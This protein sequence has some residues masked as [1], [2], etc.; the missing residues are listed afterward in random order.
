MLGRLS[1]I[2]HLHIDGIDTRSQ[3]KKAIKRGEVLI[4]GRV[5]RTGDQVQRG[6][7]LSYLPYTQH[8]PVLE[9][10][11]DVVYEDSYLCIVD[12]PA[13]LPVSGNRY[14]QLDNCLSYNLTA[15]PLEDS[16]AQPL[17]VHRLDKATS[18]LL[19]CSKTRAAHI[20]LSE[21]LHDRRI[22]KWYEAIV[23]GKLEGNGSLITPIDGKRALTTY[24]SLT[25]IPSPRYDYLTHLQLEI[26]TGRTHQIRRHCAL[27]GHPIMGDQ[28]YCPAQLRRSKGLRLQACRLAFTHPITGEPLN[29]CLPFKR[30]IEHNHRASASQDEQDLRL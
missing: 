25:I 23:F 21:Q 24:S 1:D 27:A 14:R 10:D 6:D 13:G 29:L 17:P 15:S 26:E 28:L 19:I 30:G 22:R 16:L 2:G 8:R 7:K 11:I 4:N 12:K 9:L 18:G 20:L 3:L 5:G